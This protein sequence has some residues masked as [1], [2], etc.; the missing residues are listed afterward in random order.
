MTR[1]DRSL[2]PFSVVG[3]LKSV[4]QIF[5]GMFMFDRFAITASSVVGITVSLIAGT[6]FTYVEYRNKKNKSASSTN[7]PDRTPLFDE[8][9][10]ALDTDTSVFSMSV[11]F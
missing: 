1:L 8:P 9:N 5:F 6:M 4:L 7:N 11:L 10:S 2:V 3:V